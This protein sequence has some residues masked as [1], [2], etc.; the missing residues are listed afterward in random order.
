MQHRRSTAWL[1]WL[2][3]AAGSFLI[4]SAPAQET[5][6]P[7]TP[8]PPAE[9]PTAPMR[10]QVMLRGYCLG[11]SEEWS[12]PGGHARSDNHPVA[13]TP[14]ERERQSEVA[15]VLRLDEAVDF[16]G[17]RGFRLWLV[18]G[19]AEKQ[20][21]SASDSRLPIV[22]EAQDREGR[23]RPIEY[24]PS[25]WCGNS[26]HTVFLQPGE[27][28]SFA[29]PRYEGPFATKLR[30]RMDRGRD[31]PPLLSAEF[32]GSI[33]ERQFSDKQG[34]QATNVMDPYDE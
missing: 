6:V 33:D 7:P 27:R 25:S 13:L 30:F 1:A 4:R 12:G 19:T 31:L 16:R 11:D 22:Q 32:E 2:L 8:P 21:F 23:W 18:N 9:L 14:A 17:T 28:W 34:H 29:V 26:R 15:L 20:G 24:L 3:A 10:S 5:P